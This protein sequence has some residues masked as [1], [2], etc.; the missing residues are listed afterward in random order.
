VSRIEQADGGYRVWLDGGGHCFW[1]PDYRWSIWPLHVGISVV[2][3][4]FWNPYGYYNIYDYG[5][6]W[7]GYYPGYYPGYYGGYYGSYYPGYDSGHYGG[8]YGGYY[9][10]GYGG[11]Y[12]RYETSYLQGYVD[13]FDEYAG[14]FVVR[15]D[16]SGRYATVYVRGD[17][18]Q[19]RYLQ[20]GDWV[21]LAGSWRNDY[22]E[23]FRIDELA[24]R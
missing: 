12:G 13:R 10:G 20:V 24:P 21:S 8:G 6:Y 18:P 1:I 11:G 22:F 16:R 19:F 15:D 5:P 14:T 7:G 9:S 23:A 4:G 3:G 2:F 17:D